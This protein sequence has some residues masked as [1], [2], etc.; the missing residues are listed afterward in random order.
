MTVS[1]LANLCKDLKVTVTKTGAAFAEVSPFAPEILLECWIVVILWSS[2]RRGICSLEGS[3][4]GLAVVNV[5]KQIEVVVK[6]VCSL[7]SRD[8]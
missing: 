5:R 8:G 2:R 1:T 3:L 6:E 4:P 7:V